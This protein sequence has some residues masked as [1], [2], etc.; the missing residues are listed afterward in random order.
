MKNNPV[1]RLM[2]A[3]TGVQK[4]ISVGAMKE[5][6]EFL[7][8][9][10]QTPNAVKVEYTVYN[11]NPVQHDPAYLL[12]RDTYLTGEG[13]KMLK[14][15]MSEMVRH[16]TRLAVGKKVPAIGIVFGMD[17]T[18]TIRFTAQVMLIDSL[19][20]SVKDGIPIMCSVTG[21]TKKQNAQIY[22]DV[23]D[24]AYKKLKASDM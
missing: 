6:F 13:Q 15:N 16:C 3:A 7:Y 2:L 23:V 12:P 10:A 22:N 1:N 21:G 17:E 18:D 4:V 24:D 19:R 5:T 20:S 14:M 11:P 8:N 9:L